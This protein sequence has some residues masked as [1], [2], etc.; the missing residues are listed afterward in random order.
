MQVLEADEQNVFATLGIANV[1]AE[2]NKVGEA[3][4]IL[5]GIREASP[6]HIQIPN[7]LVNLAHLNVVLENYESAINLY[8][9]ALE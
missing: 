1:L 8:N 6:S 9:K 2:F 4:E 3:I 7:V 5:K